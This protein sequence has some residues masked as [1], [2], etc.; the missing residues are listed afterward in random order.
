MATFT[1]VNTGWRAQIRRKGHKSIARTFDT[2]AEAER[3]AFDIESTIGNGTYVDNR[4][5]LSTTLQECLERYAIEVIPHKKGARQDSY[6]IKAW[7]SDPLATKG[8]GTIKQ[9]DVARWRDGRMAEGYSGGTITRDLALLSHVFT[10]AIKEWGFPIANPVLMIRKPKSNLARDRRLHPGEEELLLKHC[11]FEMRSFIILAIETA[12]RRGELAKLRREWIKGRV[13]YLPDTKNGSPRAV[14]LSKRA[15]EAIS[16]LPIRIDGKLFEYQDDAY[17]KE[18]IRV[19]KRA[20]I[21][22][23]RLHDLRHEATSRLFEKGLDV[24]QVKTIT[25]HKSLQML[26]R[27]THLK[28]DEL[29]RL[30]G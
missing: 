28:A 17:T 5:A 30:L 1:K 16:A 12:M 19:C 25:G 20:D 23:L 13:A 4:E 15:L 7:Q 6:R 8:I 9:I 24:M 14:P 3:W 26:S 27:Y 29:A 18:F 11:D 21:S 10:I 22:G 2:K